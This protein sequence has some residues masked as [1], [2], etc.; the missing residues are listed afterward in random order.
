MGIAVIN[1]SLL[2]ESSPENR[3]KLVHML[4]QSFA[5]YGFVKVVGH[6]ISDN[7]LEQLFDWVSQFSMLG[8]VEY[9]RLS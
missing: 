7:T 2:A 1:L 6:G 8:G 3:K 4:L 9:N 5:T